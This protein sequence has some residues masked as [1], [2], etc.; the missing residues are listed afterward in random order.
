VF[1]H[2]EGFDRKVEDGVPKGNGEWGI[3][4]LFHELFGI[5]VYVMGMGCHPMGLPMFRP[6][7]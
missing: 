6:L 1:D 4:P 2:F 7:L 3:S 5:R